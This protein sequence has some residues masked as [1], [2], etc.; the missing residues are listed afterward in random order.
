[1]EVRDSNSSREA[2]GRALAARARSIRSRKG[3]AREA[4]VGPKEAIPVAR[5][6][7]RAAST[8]K[9]LGRCLE[10][11]RD[12]AEGDDRNQV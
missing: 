6:R 7:R 11:I 3:S 1:M 10:A 5:V 9:S 12:R 2:A 4:V 8:R